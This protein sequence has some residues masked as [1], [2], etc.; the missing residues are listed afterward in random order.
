VLV[1][2]VVIGVILAIIMLLIVFCINRNSA[3]AQ[4]IFVI[5]FNDFITVCTGIFI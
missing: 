2:V 3:S 5:T 4:M 1:F